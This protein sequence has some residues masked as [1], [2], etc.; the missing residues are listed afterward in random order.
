LTEGR[1]YSRIEFSAERIGLAAQARLSNDFN[2]IL[3]L[4]G[5]AQARLRLLMS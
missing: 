1:V 4:T 5:R 2:Q 3:D